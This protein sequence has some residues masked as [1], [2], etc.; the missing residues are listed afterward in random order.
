MLGNDVT[1]NNTRK[2]PKACNQNLKMKHQGPKT[3]Q[4]LK[5]GKRN[6]SNVAK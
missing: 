4:L 1:K 3:K 6:T 2:T 5:S